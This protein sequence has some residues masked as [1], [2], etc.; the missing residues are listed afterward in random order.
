VIAS[1]KVLKQPWVVAFRDLAGLPEA[2]Q[3]Q[4]DTSTLNSPP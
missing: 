1:F 3:T 2:G 4:P